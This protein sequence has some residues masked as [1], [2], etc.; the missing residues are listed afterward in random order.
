MTNETKI[1]V[2]L[3]GDIG[4]VD[5]KKINRLPRLDTPTISKKSFHVSEWRFSVDELNGV[6]SM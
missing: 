6:E 2:S 5:Q 4:S 3:G 1:K